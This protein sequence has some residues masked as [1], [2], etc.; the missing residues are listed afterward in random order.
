MCWRTTSAETASGNAIDYIVLLMYHAN[1]LMC[2]LYTLHLI[3][4]GAVCKLSYVE[5]TNTSV[6]ITWKSPKEP[7]GDIVAYFVEH[8]VYQNEST[9][10]V[11]LHARR[12]MHTV[13]GALGKLLPFHI[14]AIYVYVSIFISKYHIGQTLPPYLL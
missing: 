13:I 14:V 7:N 6:H 8:G 12:P 5:D 4:P 2:S 11:R 9:S 3:V 10:A 1:S